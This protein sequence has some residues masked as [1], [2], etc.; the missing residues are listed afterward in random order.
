MN[1]C[2]FN[3]NSESKYIECDIDTF[4]STENINRKNYNIIAKFTK[5]RYSKKVYNKIEI[6]SRLFDNI[7]SL[8]DLNTKKVSINYKINNGYNKQ[9]FETNNS[10]GTNSENEIKI[11]EG[12]FRCCGSGDNDCLQGNIELQEG[13]DLSELFESSGGNIDLQ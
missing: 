11:N 7:F 13:L 8:R 6:N 4:M 12:V 9:I 2:E 3:N 1:L 10:V 5:I